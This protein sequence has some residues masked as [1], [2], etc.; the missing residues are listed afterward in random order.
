MLA[1]VR[2]V[3]RQWNQIM[4]GFVKQCFTFCT[5]VGMTVVWGG[6]P[7]D[8]Y[9]IPFPHAPLQWNALTSDFNHICFSFECLSHFMVWFRALATD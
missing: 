4:R 8:V 1:N 7:D 5:I 9:G 2:S 3:E 6:H